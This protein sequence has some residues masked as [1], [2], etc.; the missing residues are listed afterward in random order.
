MKSIQVS[1]LLSLMALLTPSVAQWDMMRKH[2]PAMKEMA[3]S[4]G[5]QTI[6]DDDDLIVLG[7]GTFDQ[8]LDHSD[9]SKGTFKQRYWWNA[10]FFEEG[11][12]VFLF[13]PGEMSA[14]AAT[15]YMENYTL[16]GYYAQQ[17]KGAVIL[18]EH[19]YWGESIPV[20]TLTA[21]TLQ[22]L[23][24]PNSIQDLTYFAKNV[25]C[26]FCEDS[27][28]NS[29][30][31]PWVLMGGSYSGALAA[32]TS[33]LDPGTFKAYH[34]SSAVVEAIYDFW[35][36]AW[37]I[38]QAL[39]MNC[40]ADVNA[41]IQYIDS[42]LSYGSADD[43][44]K[45]KSQFGLSALNDADFAEILARPL[46]EWQSDQS[47]VF[48]FCDYMQKHTQWMGLS[49]FGR[50]LKAALEGY[51]SF[52]KETIDCGENGAAC[53]T[54]S[55]AIAWNNAADLDG[56]YRQWQWM[57]CNEPFGWYQT[58][59]PRADGSSII[60][61][62][63]TAD[64]YQRRC[65]LTFPETNG[66]R[67]GSIVGFTAD[68]LNL[69][70]KGWDAP[71]DRVLFVNGE[72]DPWR[73]ATVASD[74]RPGGAVSSD[75]IPS[76]IIEKGNHVPDLVLGSSPYQTVVVQRAVEIMGAWLKAA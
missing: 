17:F 30:E 74:Y 63:L 28:C 40:S 67:A 59:P 15:G 53:N 32:W 39:P 55:E 21:E 36:Y 37:P 22:Y 52:I 61:S 4:T 18:L 6:L 45:V 8:L 26:Q 12:P 70:T 49:D 66:Y 25:N 19:R 58:G 34:A 27:T 5:H 54:Y 1:G 64:H 38:H 16:P 51:S 33:Q 73:S 71:F 47:A 68:H 29:D 20:E 50:D 9:P 62:A 14:G 2:R 13:N 7:K 72:H 10:E 11:G 76:L 41:V 56:G 65:D 35:E 31:N 60:L 46:F 3:L 23:N 57:L 75:K 24:L 69:W 44:T 48:S 43:V 42:V